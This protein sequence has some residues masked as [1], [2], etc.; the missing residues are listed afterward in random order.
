MKGKKLLGIPLSIVMLVL[1]LM[2]VGT[3][4]YATI[5]FTREVPSHVRI[6]S[7]WELS[8]WKD[9]ACTIELT[10]I[11]FGKI[12]ANQ[13]I[14]ASIL[15]LK[16]E[17]SETI[18]IGF[19]QTG[20]DAAHLK[21]TGQGFDGNCPPDPFTY[22]AISGVQTPLAPDEVRAIRLQLKADSEAT[23]GGV[24]FIVII[25]ASDIAY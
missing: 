1:C 15:Y 18:Y 23:R 13:T 25:N 6:I 19:S 12:S 14:T 21:L 7:P 5:M 3:G 10:A 22:P 4:V 9:E 8:A 11:D 17:S 2:L 20:L 24:D 16:N